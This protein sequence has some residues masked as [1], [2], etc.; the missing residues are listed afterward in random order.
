MHGSPAMEMDLEVE[1]ELV[2]EWTADAEDDV[3]AESLED[4]WF[5]RTEDKLAELEDAPSPETL[6]GRMM[7]MIGFA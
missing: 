7:R 5:H 6:R 2:Y 3:L 4:A 1:M